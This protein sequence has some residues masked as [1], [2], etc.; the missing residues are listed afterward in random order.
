MESLVFNGSATSDRQ[1][2]NITILDDDLR[3]TSTFSPQPEVFQVLLNVSEPNDAVQLGVQTASV[4]IE[5]DDCKYSVWN[6]T[7]GSS[8]LKLIYVTKTD[9][10]FAQVVFHIVVI[11]CLVCTAKH[12]TLADPCMVIVLIL[13]F[14]QDVLKLVSVAVALPLADFLKQTVGV[15]R[16]A[17][18]GETAV[19]T[20]SKHAHEVRICKYI[21]YTLLNVSLKCIDY[22]HTIKC[23]ILCTDP[24]DFATCGV[25]A[26]CISGNST[27]GTF[28]CVCNPGFAG[29]PF[30]SCISKPYLDC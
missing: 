25:N 21:M 22:I 27:N 28:D 8:V 7:S 4:S 6:I 13:Q 12:C 23:Y 30:I 11:Q 3:E 29:N 15:M 24:C 20:Y 2:V 1:C 16:A 14:P 18:E 9:W 17:M 26:Q 19:M 5:D 10:C